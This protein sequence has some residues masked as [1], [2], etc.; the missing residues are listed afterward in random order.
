M[1][2][3]RIDRNPML[4]P[5]LEF[6]VRRAVD[7]L[8]RF[9]VNRAR[10]YAA[11]RGSTSVPPNITHRTEKTAGGYEAKIVLQKDGFKQHFFE[12][13]TAP[14]YAKR[15]KGKQLAK[16]AYRGQVSA[17]PVFEP[18]KRD[19]LRRGLNLRPF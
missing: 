19:A 11:A 14:R 8:G 4:E 10:A 3:V 7:E 12:Q 15:C 18:A 17:R 1:P 9:A 16:P 5:Q 6:A 2:D 13:G